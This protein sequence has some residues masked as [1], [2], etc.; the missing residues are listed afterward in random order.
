MRTIGVL[1]ASV[2][3]F[4]CV[5]RNVPVE[6]FQPA[7]LPADQGSL[8][9][10]FVAMT[11]FGL[12]PVVAGAD[13]YGSEAPITTPWEDAGMFRTRWLAYV[14]DGQLHITSVCFQALT[15][16]AAQGANQSP[17]RSTELVRCTVQPRGRSKLVAE[18]AAEIGTRAAPPE[19]VEPP[20]DAPP[21]SPFS[22]A[23]ND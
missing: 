6:P 14:R 3:A 15:V 7:A 19:P 23:L 8:H 13:A 10:T 21:P 5:K 4:G 1:A 9:R 16:T 11:W 20:P 2:L 18:L 22:P 12:E 17:T